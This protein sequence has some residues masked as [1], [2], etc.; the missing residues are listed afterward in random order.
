M[1]LIRFKNIEADYARIRTINPEYI[2]G[3]LPVVLNKIGA[4]GRGYRYNQVV[5]GFA[6]YKSFH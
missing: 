1:I 6:N 5:Q 4:S 3:I 2:Y